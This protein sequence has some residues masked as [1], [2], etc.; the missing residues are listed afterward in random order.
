MLKR[1]IPLL[2]ASIVLLGVGSTLLGLATAHLSPAG[3]GAAVVLAVAVLVIVGATWLWGSNRRVQDQH[4]SFWSVL[5]AA[6][7]PRHD[8]HWLPW[9]SVR[10]IFVAWVVAIVCL[11]VLA[12]VIG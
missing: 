8:D 9:I 5:K 2:G 7:P 11:G 6:K 1:L 10:V 12:T 4:L 3:R